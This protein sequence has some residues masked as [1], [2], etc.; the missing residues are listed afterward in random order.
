MAALCFGPRSSTCRNTTAVANLTCLATKGLKPPRDETDEISGLEDRTDSS[1]SFY[2]RSRK[3]EGNLCRQG[4]RVEISLGVRREGFPGMKGSDPS[5]RLVRQ[6]VKTRSWPKIGPDPAL[7]RS[8]AHSTASVPDSFTTAIITANQPAISDSPPSGTIAAGFRHDGP[9]KVITIRQPLNRSTPTRN[10]NP[11]RR[12]QGLGVDCAPSQRSVNRG[13]GRSGS[14]QPSRTRP[15]FA[16]NSL[17]SPATAAWKKDHAPVK[18]PRATP[19]RRQQRTGH[20]QYASRGISHGLT[21]WQ[22]PAELLLPLPG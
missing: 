4:Y 7:L 2:D 1:G 8:T 22:F 20:Q 17:G 11:A 3:V 13:H 19:L 16:P 15:V 14:G 6:S 21:H 18:A 12:S 10:K 9:A 5:F